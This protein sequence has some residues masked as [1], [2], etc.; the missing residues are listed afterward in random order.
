[1]LVSTAGTCSDVCGIQ[2]SGLLLPVVVVVV[3]V[4]PLGQRRLAIAAAGA[5]TVFCISDCF[6]QPAHSD[7]Q[8]LCRV[9]EMAVDVNGARLI[10]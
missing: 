4:F 8:H 10:D 2:T 3:V 1:M 5:A 9:Q 7:C 6:G